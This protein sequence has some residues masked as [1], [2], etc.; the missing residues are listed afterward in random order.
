MLLRRFVLVC[1][2]VLTT[3]ATVLAQDPTDNAE[4]ETTQETPGT[5][6]TTN[7]EEV[8]NI[9]APRHAGQTVYDSTGMSFVASLRARQYGGGAIETLRVMEDN[10]AFTR[11]LI[12]Y[13]SDGLTIQGFMNVPK[14]EGPFPAV[15]VAHGYVYPKN[16]PVLTYMTPYADYLA[17]SGYLVVHPNYRGHGWSDDGPNPFRSGYTI[18]VLNLIQILK[19]DGRVRPDAIGIFGHSMGGEVAIKAL[20]VSPDIRAAVLYASMSA[21]AL[22]SWRLINNTWAYGWFLFDGP[23]SPW[24]DFEAFRLA[25][26][27][28]F[29]DYVQAPV[30]LHHGTA[31]GTVPLEWSQRLTRLLREHGKDADLFQYPGAPHGFGIGSVAYTM[32]ME[33]STL[34]FGQHLGK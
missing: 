34:F 5:E 21:D 25:S 29:L 23:F 19:A 12:N 24:R 10:T 15:V 33:R 14:G 3:T 28:N 1:F 18:D 32:L 4:S 30:Q 22:E 31:D 9:I 16:Y 13:P 7:P 17:R 11:Y 27:I 8:A 20:V 26:P 6:Q 2:L